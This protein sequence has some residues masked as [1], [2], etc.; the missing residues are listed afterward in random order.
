M[1]AR[2]AQYLHRVI[3]LCVGTDVDYEENI[4]M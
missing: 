1:I 2:T 4:T 3:Q